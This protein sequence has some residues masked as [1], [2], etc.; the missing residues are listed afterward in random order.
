MSIALQQQ[1]TLSLGMFCGPDSKLIKIRAEIHSLFKKQDE[2][3]KII[4]S[5]KWGGFHINSDI[6]MVFYDTSYNKVIKSINEAAHTFEGFTIKPLC[7]N[8]I[9]MEINGTKIQITLGSIT[10]FQT[11]RIH[12][13][14]H[15]KIREFMEA[16]QDMG[17]V[18]PEMFRLVNFRAVFVKMMGVIYS[19]L[20]CDEKYPHAVHF[21]SLGAI[22]KMMNPHVPSLVIVIMMDIAR[23]V[24][25]PIIH[26]DPWR[27]G[28]HVVKKFIQ[29]YVLGFHD[30]LFFNA[31]YK[32]Y[33]SLYFNKHVSLNEPLFPSTPKARDVTDKRYILTE[34]QNERFLR[35]DLLK[36]IKEM[37]ELPPYDPLA[38]PPAHAVDAN[39]I[40]F[41]TS[42][43]IISNNYP[44]D[45]I[46][47]LMEAKPV[48]FVA[49]TPALTNAALTEWLLSAEEGG[50]I[51]PEAME[52]VSSFHFHK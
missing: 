32:P 4:G 28:V 18:P 15:P 13:G 29:C 42:F 21:R 6:D 10:E 26:E 46:C 31:V 27:F 41:A 25:D 34:W 12:D 47:K 23:S 49:N 33:V 11:M 50:E 37:P 48:E 43:V 20:Y 51:P 45:E 16:V 40:R 17:A 24:Y 39:I 5:S 52:F 7:Y 30:K 8:L 19:N 22:L 3:F 1:T 36:T 35:S 38:P 44:S 9:Q 2:N 14:I